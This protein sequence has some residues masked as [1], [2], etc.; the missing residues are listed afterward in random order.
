MNM[1][2]GVQDAEISSDLRYVELGITYLESRVA[3]A[4]RLA[5]EALVATARL[6]GFKGDCDTPETRF[7][8]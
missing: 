1:N 6:Q 8:P 4:I 3:V 5:E 7:A 2:S